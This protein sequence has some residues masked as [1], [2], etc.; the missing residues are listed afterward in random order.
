[1]IK[2]IT[3]IIILGFALGLFPSSL[4]AADS[5]I[6][7]VFDNFKSEYQLNQAIDLKA[8]LKNNTPREKSVFVLTNIINSEQTSTALKNPIPVVIPAQQSVQVS[9][10]KGVIDTGYFTAKYI[11]SVDI[12]DEIQ[13]FVH[14]EQSFQVNASQ[15]SKEIDFSWQIC[16]DENCNYPKKVFSNGELIFIKASSSL[17]EVS[18]A[19][20]ITQPDNSKIQLQTGMPFIP[21]QLGLYS[22]NIIAEKPGFDRTEKQDS[23]SLNDANIL[24]VTDGQCILD[25]VCNPGETSQNCP[26]DC[27]EKPFNFAVPILVIVI[28]VLVLIIGLIV[29]K[30]FINK[31]R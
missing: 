3:A 15:S 11:A 10:I 1:M 29:K 13:N 30:R 24:P 26:Q 31:S 12:V 25:N 7:V 9:I 23:F 16:P 27:N 5:D 17:E 18:F 6:S 19:Y 14:K 21:V 22:L 20:E 2:I 28:G 8:T 4:A